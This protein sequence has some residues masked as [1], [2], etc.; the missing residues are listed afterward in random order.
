MCY[1]THNSSSSISVRSTAASATPFELIKAYYMRLSSIRP[2]FSS[3]L[4]KRKSR[5]I[6]VKSD[7]MYI[8]KRLGMLSSLLKPKWR[9]D[10][11]K[12]SYIAV[13]GIVSSC[14]GYRLSSIVSHKT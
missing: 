10:G 4:V 12:Q 2:F 13:Q 3:L 7:K 8:C 6:Q 11:V 1:S 9:L 14:Q 5:L